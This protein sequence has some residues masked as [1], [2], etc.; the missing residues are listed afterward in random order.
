MFRL[1]DYLQVDR[2]KVVLRPKH[3]ADNLNKI[4]NN[5]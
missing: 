5:Y 1:Y 2:L 4:V 3:I